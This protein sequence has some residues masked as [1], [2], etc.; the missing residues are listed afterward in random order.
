MPSNISEKNEREN[1]RE[2]KRK[3]KSSLNLCE[4]QSQII[5]DNYQISM[6]Q[7]KISSHLSTSITII[8]TKFLPIVRGTVCPS[9][10]W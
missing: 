6:F 4:S 10:D 3:H 9:I 1:E 2:R 8:Y 5:P 7:Y